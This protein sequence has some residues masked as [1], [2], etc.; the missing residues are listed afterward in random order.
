MIYALVA[1]ADAQSIADVIDVMADLKRVDAP[2]RPLA[3]L[4]SFGFEILIRKSMANGL[5]EAF[6]SSETY[7]RYSQDRAEAG[8]F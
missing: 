1:H 2:G 8:A 5:A 6:Q 3:E 4:T 7:Q